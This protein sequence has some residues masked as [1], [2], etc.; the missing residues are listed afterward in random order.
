MDRISRRD[1]LVTGSAV[2]AGTL[3]KSETEAAEAQAVQTPAA[4]THKPDT[5]GASGAAY[6]LECKWIEKIIDGTK[7]RLRSYNGTV[8]GPLLKTKPGDTLRVRVKN[9]LKAYDAI[10]QGIHG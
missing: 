6:E 1:L 9:S 5:A 7:V 8:P 10:W 4:P 2:L 3:V